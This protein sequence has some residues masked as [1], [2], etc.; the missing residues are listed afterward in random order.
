[1]SS[2]EL[3]VV[4]KCVWWKIRPLSNLYHNYAVI[5]VHPA[6]KLEYAL[7]LLAVLLHSNDG[8][9]PDMLSQDLLPFVALCPDHHKTEFIG[10][11]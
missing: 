3:H 10:K 11:A 4:K 9:G 6:L 1:M 7:V 8:P 2:A 5:G